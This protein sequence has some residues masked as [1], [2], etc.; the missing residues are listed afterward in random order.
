MESNP[1]RRTKR[2]RTY[3]EVHRSRVG[4]DEGEGGGKSAHPT[5]I[6]LTDRALPGPLSL[7]LSL[8]LF[9]F[10]SLCSASFMELKKIYRG[11]RVRICARARALKAEDAGGREREEDFFFTSRALRNIMLI[12]V[13]LD[14]EP[15]VYRWY[16]SAH[17]R[18][19]RII[20]AFLVFPFFLYTQEREREREREIERESECREGG[21]GKRVEPGV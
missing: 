7:S 15:S 5:R 19:V 11:E 9:Y 8:S 18:Y 6:E 21:R 16:V 1:R 2:A 20:F 12:G 13:T 3:R 10:L 14:E 4:R 17:V